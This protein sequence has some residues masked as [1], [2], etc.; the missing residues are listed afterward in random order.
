RVRGHPH[1]NTRTRT[2]PGNQL[3]HCPRNSGL[4]TGGLPVERGEE[5]AT[6]QELL[7]LVGAGRGVH[8]APAHEARY[9]ARPNIAYVPFA[10]APPLE[11]GL[12]WR[13]AAETGRVRAFADAAAEVVRKQGGPGGV[14]GECR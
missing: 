13:T 8:P 1:G 4:D 5:A 3:T 10:D 6:R 12:V 14:C 9:Y 2:C 7:A 11:Y